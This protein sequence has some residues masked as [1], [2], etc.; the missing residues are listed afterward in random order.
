MKVYGKNHWKWMVDHF[1]EVMEQGN[2]DAMELEE[3]R[4]VADSVTRYLQLDKNVEEVQNH[5]KY[6]LFNQMKTMD[7]I[8][9]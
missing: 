7:Q 8:H 2:A 5:L 4:S 9:F 6:N 1:C 3:M